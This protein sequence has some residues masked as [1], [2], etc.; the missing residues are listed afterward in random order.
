MMQVR[1]T[2]LKE[3][4][5]LLRSL[6][7]NIRREVRDV[8]IPQMSRLLR[9]NIRRSFKIRGYGSSQWSSKKGFKSIEYKK[10]KQGAIV[11]VGFGRTEEYMRML[12]EGFRMHQ[13]SIGVLKRHE[14]MPGSTVGKTAKELGVQPE[15]YVT[16]HWRGPFV[17]PALRRFRPKIPTHLNKFVQRAIQKSR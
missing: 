10:T 13:V 14:S 9:D 2:G 11:Y 8:G 5:K 1:V 17:E 12:E 3:T 7:P 6:P 15:G 4:Q 16:V